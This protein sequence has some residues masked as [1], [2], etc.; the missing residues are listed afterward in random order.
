[1]FTTGDVLRSKRMNSHIEKMRKANQLAND[2]GFATIDD[3]IEATIIDS[4]APGICREPDCDYSTDVEP[5]QHRGW[6]EVC[7][8]NT[9]QSILIICGIV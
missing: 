9:V 3:C 8:K 4:V 6:C 1:M 7:G 2:Y 5:D